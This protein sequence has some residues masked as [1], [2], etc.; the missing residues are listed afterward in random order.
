M[1]L[2]SSHGKDIQQYP[3]L[4]SSSI[5]HPVSFYDQIYDTERSVDHDGNRENKLVLEDQVYYMH[6]MCAKL[7][8]QRIH[9]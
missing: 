4:A 5:A 3:L 7:Y 1:S 2:Y 8:V 9:L 6:R